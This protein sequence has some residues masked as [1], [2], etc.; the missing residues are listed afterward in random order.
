MVRQ[1]PYLLLEPIPMQARAV[2]EDRMRQTRGQDVGHVAPCATSLVI[3]HTLPD[4]ALR[5]LP[6]FG[7]RFAS[8]GPRDLDRG[9]VRRQPGGI[10]EGE[11][12]AAGAVQDFRVDEEGAGGI[13]VA[14]AVVGNVEGGQM[15]ENVLTVGRLGCVLGRIDAEAME[16][17]ETESGAGEE[18]EKA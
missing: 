12:D 4:D 3:F 18:D 8:G 7:P 10:P 5:I 15:G 9:R 1:S 2:N 6:H 16:S 11:C 17:S 13:G 14:M